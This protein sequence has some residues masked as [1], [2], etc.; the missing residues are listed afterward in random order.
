MR[1]RLSCDLDP[2]KVSV[3]SSGVGNSSAS[4]EKWVCPRFQF[5]IRSRRVQRRPIGRG[6]PIPRRA[7]KGAKPRPG[8]PGPCVHVPWEQ[9]LAVLRWLPF[10]PMGRGRLSHTQ[11]HAFSAARWNGT[12]SC[13]RFHHDP[14]HFSQG[15]ESRPPPEGKLGA[16][17]RCVSC[18]S[19]G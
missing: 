7:G 8:C 14:P 18:L 19:P 1:P 10:L 4:P 15:C 12:P 17:S 9:T 11:G 13:A 16:G 3:V 5:I 2:D 6:R